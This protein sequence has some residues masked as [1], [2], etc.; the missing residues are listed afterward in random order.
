MTDDGPGRAGWR[1][2]ASTLLLGVALAACAPGAGVASPSGAASSAAASGAGGAV[3]NC[4]GRATT[5]YGWEGTVNWSYEVDRTGM[6]P[7]YSPQQQQAVFVRQSAELTIRADDVELYP[8]PQGSPAGGNWFASRMTGSVSVD[9]QSIC[10]S[11]DEGPVEDDFYAQG[12]GPPLT[13]GADGRAGRDPNFSNFVLSVQFDQCTYSF[14]AAAFV[15]G[16]N[17]QHPTDRKVF[18]GLASLAALSPNVRLIAEADLTLTG[19]GSFPAAYEGFGSGM[20]GDVLQLGGLSGDVEFHGLGT[21][22][23]SSGTV[24]WSLT[25]IVMP[26]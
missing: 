7:N 1:S 19:S 25:P 4:G 24:S 14:L 20:S 23:D 9:D 10:A 12:S 11:C 21:S 3:L 17:S 5:I 6:S 2:L 8:G 16:V 22:G 13:E 26:Q 18:A 15:D